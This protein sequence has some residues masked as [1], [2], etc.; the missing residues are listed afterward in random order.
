M[1]GARRQFY[2]IAYNSKIDANTNNQLKTKIKSIMNEPFF[3]NNKYYDSVESLIDEIVLNDCDIE[4]L[5]DDYEIQATRAQLL[6]IIQYKADDLLEMADEFSE[7]N[8]D[9][10]VEQILNAI[11]E[12]C[13]FD[14]LNS[15]IPKLWYEMPTERFIITKADLL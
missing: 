5:P 3:S 9:R 8:C 11:K 6:P 2:F 4:E 1:R 13:D 10:E 15:M 7:E 14:K 12:C